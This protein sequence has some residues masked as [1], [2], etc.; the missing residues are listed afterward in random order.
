M[1]SLRIYK[2]TQGKISTI[3][4]AN[5]LHPLQAEKRNDIHKMKSIHMI[6][7]CTMGQ[8]QTIPVCFKMSLSDNLY[9]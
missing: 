1:K 6:I 8:Q 5:F 4:K 7:W 3:S 9:H 2:K